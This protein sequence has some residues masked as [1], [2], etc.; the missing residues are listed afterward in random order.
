[1]NWVNRNKEGGRK[2]YLRDRRDLLVVW[3]DSTV[4]GQGLW[5]QKGVFAVPDFPTHQLCFQHIISLSLIFLLYKMGIA[6]VPISFF[7][8]EV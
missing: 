5:T 2:K 3:A 1:M 4:W 7:Q 6:N 8:I